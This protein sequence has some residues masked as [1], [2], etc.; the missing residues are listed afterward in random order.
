LSGVDWL[1]GNQSRVKPIQ[2]RV[3]YLCLSHS[4][5][6]PLAQQSDILEWWGP[7]LFRRW[8]S[9]PVIILQKPSHVPPCTSTCSGAP[10]LKTE[11]FP[12]T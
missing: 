10:F 4:P 3:G 11:L 9:P 2:L 12:N 6:N 7:I 8:W 1:L 5:K